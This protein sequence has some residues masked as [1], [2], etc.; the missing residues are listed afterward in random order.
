[1]L[2]DTQRYVVPVREAMSRTSGHWITLHGEDSDEG[3][4]HVYVSGAG[5]YITKGPAALIGSSMAHLAGH[6]ATHHAVG[7]VP[8]GHDQHPSYTEHASTKAAV[9]PVKDENAVKNPGKPYARDHGAAQTRSEPTYT[10]PVEGPTPLTEEQSKAGLEKARQ[11]QAKTTDAPDTSK[12]APVFRVE[13]TGS[14][15]GQQDGYILT[16]PSAHD[17]PAG[18]LDFSVMGDSVYI[19]MVEVNEHQRRQ[20]Y[21]RALMNKLKEEFPDKKISWGMMTEDGGAFKAGLEKAGLEKARGELK[22]SAAATPTPATVSDNEPAA[23]PDKAQ[24]ELKFDGTPPARTGAYTEPTSTAKPAT[25]PTETQ[26]RP[27]MSYKDIENDTHARSLIDK[28]VQHDEETKAVRDRLQGRFHPVLKDMDRADM[29]L[30]QEFAAHTGKSYA[31]HMRSRSIDA[32]I[33]RGDF[34]PPKPSDKQ[35]A[36]EKETARLAAK[37]DDSD[38]S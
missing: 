10:T 6:K 9:A 20:G 11:E 4:V 27:R 3:T 36:E 30:R 5:G 28:I 35:L 34:E 29:A 14:H 8:T 23:A 12:A 7:K 32:G 2:L 1:M 37:S 33:R 13:Y 19:N 17:K 38:I 26:T 15:H 21:G 25:A 22:A 24:A 18:H 16:G 31:E